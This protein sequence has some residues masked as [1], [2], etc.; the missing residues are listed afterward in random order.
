MM[1][2]GM[3]LLFTMVGRLEVRAAGPPGTHSV[4]VTF[5]AGRPGFR[6]MPAGE[7]GLG[8][9]NVLAEERSLTNTIVN[10]GSGVA[11]GD[12]DGDGLCDIYFCS[13]DG[14][15]ALYRNL[16]GWRF[17]NIAAAAGVD[18]PRSL[19][20][21]ALLGDVD[22]DGDLDLLVNAIGGGTRLFL[23]DRQGRFAENTASGLWRRSGATS[24]ALADIDGDGDLDLYVANYRTSTIMDEP[25]VRFTIART[26]GQFVLTKVNGV[27]VTSPELR[28]RFFVGPNGNPRE[29]GEADV[30]Y[31]NDGNGHFTPASWTDGTF[32][33]EAGQPLT[34][35]PRDWGLSVLFRDLNGDGS[36]DLYV[37]ND[38]D[39]PD[40]V[41][42][43]DGRGR[44][45]APPWLALR[46]TCLSSMGADCADLNR[47][48]FD[49]LLVLDML[50]RRRDKQH[51]QLE[52]SRPPYLAPGVLESR[53]QYSRN[54]LLLNRGDTTYAD[55]AYF[56]GLPASDW[57]W[58]PVF[59]DVDLDGFEDLL[60][61]NG[62]HREVEDIDVADRIRQAKAGRQLSPRDELLMRSL[63]PRWETPNLAFRNEGNLEFREVGTEWG[64]DWVGVSQ[65]M[66]LG[67]LDNDG[68]LDVVLNNLNG[69]A[70]LYRNETSAGRVGVRLKGQG[71]NTRGIGARVELSGGAVARQAQE[72]QAGGRYLGG[73][74][75]MRVF[76]SGEAKSGMELEVKWRS[77][78][79]SVITGVEA[80]RIYEVDE[81]QA[82]PAVPASPAL[83]TA[84]F[85]D[86]SARLGHRHQEQ[87]V[88]DF[89]RQPLLTRRLS[90]LGPGVAW[91]D[92]NGDGWE[93]LV[94]GS[95]RG[96]T[97]GVMVN[98][99]QGAFGRLNLPALQERAEDDQT[100]VVGWMAERGHS[101]LMVGVAN[102]ES[103]QG[104]GVQ[105]V[106]VFFG[107]VEK[108]PAVGS[109][110][111]SVGPLAVSDIDADGSL[112]LFV[113]C[114]V[115][116]GK[117]PVSGASR[118]F[119]V[120]EGRWVVDEAWTQAVEGA[121]M[122]SGAIWTDLAGDGYA[123]M[124]LACEWGP[125][126]VYRN[127]GG[128]LSGWDAPVQW[129]GRPEIKRLS[130]LTGWWTG[131]SAGDLDGDGQMDLVVG[132]WGLNNRYREY[133]RSH[134]PLGL[135]HGDV[136]ANG[137]WEV[138]ETHEDGGREVPWRDWKAMKAAV[139]LLGE[140]FGSY[141]AYA[142]AGLGEIFGEGLKQMEVL[143]VGVLESVV[144]LNR[145]D[146]FEARALPM[147][148]QWAPVFGVNVGDADG[149]GRED[150]FLGQNF[151]GTEAELGRY[152]AGRGL[153]LSGDGQGGFNVLSG[154][155][156]GVRVYG[157]QR[158]SALGDYDGDGRVDL[159][160]TQ[161][162]GE[163]RLYRNVGGKAGLRVRLVGDGGNGLGFGAVVR[164]GREGK[165]GPAR[166]VHGGG[167][168]WSQDSAVQVLARP[169]GA[170]EVL[171]RWPGGKTTRTPVPPSAREIEIK[172]D[173][174]A[175]AQ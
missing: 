139:P 10:N 45:R 125:V 41:W 149:D 151:F 40:R 132:N 118:V 173:G 106:E 114:R 157:E 142:Q 102:Y 57:A 154:E 11:L 69:P 35:A 143:R 84:L 92:L 55:I 19:S 36:P 129:V 107:N 104:G 163:T 95:G 120:K 77:G 128:R 56:S 79:R 141:A 44:F 48:G 74:E 127:Q 90:Q 89:E 43:N 146:F 58:C 80:N 112:D 144:L 34:E 53:P 113:G 88:D 155:A 28:A 169:E 98:N 26:N 171:V 167:G 140:R 51:T 70:G 161:N 27:P 60:I 105:Q 165:W 3:L 87:G 37:C 23:N 94:V 1:I 13:L 126:R 24:M 14:S 111:G 131:V 18:L 42:I 85:E 174:T 7:T 86:A 17:T 29:A 153:W 172:S 130:D 8:F 110:E 136:D 119:R 16:G 63:F 160:T 150:V 4:A 101:T 103:G 38:S 54:V 5:P 100:G 122:V 67:D 175:G 148:A 47:D 9:T 65:G 108:A 91:L 39:S 49:D 15:N 164:V 73:D 50:A 135:R 83:V 121:G 20:T 116:G 6:A 170:N 82:Q 75:A 166:E 115:M 156:S 97:L 32:L 138:V 31:H 152:D 168:Y 71:G 12:V 52:K 162:G 76:A 66:A 2:G 145:G 137:T 21:G 96:G 78:R 25:G 62:F 124:V 159:V 147:E 158:G 64:F 30:L 33:D 134:T 123:E 59:L 99:R 117:Y 68:D 46:H 109:A 93:D 72:I 133:L 81:A 61:A 22:G